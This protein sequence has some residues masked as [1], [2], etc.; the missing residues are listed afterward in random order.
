M[1]QSK[2]V[3]CSVR[4]DGATIRAWTNG[5]N[6]DTGH[7]ITGNIATPTL[8]AIGAAYYGPSIISE[9][10]DGHMGEIIIFN[11]ALNDN[12]M[13]DIEEYL[14]KKWLIK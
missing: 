13:D 8:I 1:A 2:P 5:A 14:Q 6:P 12:E 3:I 7:A 4:Y 11:R 10:F 9:Y